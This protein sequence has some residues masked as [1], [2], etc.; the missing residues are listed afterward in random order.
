[1]IIPQAIEPY[2]DKAKLILNK[3][4]VRDI[5]FS[6][7]TYQILIDDPDVLEQ[8]WAFLQL[9]GTGLPK[10]YFCSC[11]VGSYP[12][13]CLH[14]AT[15]YLR[16]YNG[17]ERPLHQRFSISLWNQ[18]CRLSSE[19]G[20]L[21]PK[22]NNR[23]EGIDPEGN[24]FFSIQLKDPHLAPQL[25]EIIHH[26][27]EETEETSIKFSN[28]PQEE[29][30]KWR[31]GQ[32]SRALSY[33]LSY[34]ND[35]AKWLMLKQD[36]KEHFTLSFS[37]RNDGLPC[38]LTADF[39]TCTVNFSF[40]EKEL[41]LLI[42]TLKTVPSPIAVHDDPAEE[43]E[44]IT[45]DPQT[46]E[47]VVHAKSKIL[48]VRKGKATPQSISLHGWI[49]ITGEGFYAQDQH[50]L[51]ESP[52]FQG[53]RISRLLDEHF[54]L[55]QSLLD[56]TQLYEEQVEP[57]YTLAFDAK[58][59]LRIQAY[60]F[61]PGD[62]DL[63]LSKQFRDW[64]YIQDDGFYRLKDPY[65][66][67]LA[68][69]IPPDLLS[70][71]INQHRIWL[72]AQPGFET[73]LT[74]VETQVDYQLDRTNTLTFTRIG[75]IGKR[76]DFGQWVYFPKEGFFPKVRSHLPLPFEKGIPEDQVPG[77][78][79]LNRAE[80][81]LVPNFF[82]ETNPIQSLGL[83]IALNEKEQLVISPSIKFLPSYNKEEIRLIDGFVFIKG[84]GFYECPP[85]MRIPEHY[86]TEQVIEKKHLRQF[87]TVEMEELSPWLLSVDPKLKR[88]SEI[89]LY[90]DK[91]TPT[92]E[93]G[94]Y[95]ILMRY[96]TERGSLPIETISKKS[97]EGSEFLF[98][99]AGLLDLSEAR[100]RW[101]HA[102]HKKQV[103]HTDHGIVLST[104]ELLRLKV[105]E[106]LYLNPKDEKNYEEASA[107]LQEITEGLYFE[108][109]NLKGLKSTLRPYQ[110]AGVEWLWFLYQHGLS[111]LL[112]DDMG[113]GKTHQTM[114]LI[115][116]SVNAE[117]EKKRKSHFLII[118][119][120][121]VIYHWEEKLQLFL[122]HMRTCT[123]H[124]TARSL[125]DFHHEYDILLTSYGIWRNEQELLGQV[126]FE[127]AIF[128]EIQ[129]AKNRASRIHK[130]LTHVDAK[131]RVGL[132]GT[133]LENYL[134]ELKSL[135]DI[136]VPHYMPTQEEYKNFFVIPIEK[137]GNIER[138]L[139]LSRFI[140]PFILRRKKG[141]VL[142]DL[143]DKIEEISHCELSDQQYELYNS[144]LH[145]TRNQILREME[146]DKP[147][148]PYLHIFTILS[149]LKQICNHPA[150]YLKCPEDYKKYQSGKWDLFIEL[151]E[152]ARA[153]SQKIVI[154]SQYLAMIDI[155]ENHLHESGIKFASIRGS[156]RDRAH[157][158]RLF[159]HN[160]EYEVFVGSL[161]AVGLG[162]DLTAGS[163]VIHYDR[164]WNAAR[165]NQATD[166][167]HRI[168][169]KRGVQVFK[170]VTKG[171]FE[172]R[173]DQLILRKGR[174]MEEVIGSDNS[175]VIKRFDRNELLH[176]L[177][178]CTR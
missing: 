125:K 44:K 112:C 99:D 39:E 117:K 30:D 162:V 128:D 5:V 157:Q 12:D 8:Y 119:P 61:N 62:L 98:S 100:F 36:R 96:E 43:I 86:Q 48:Q 107:I 70:G 140:K 103:E 14:I 145:Q 131:M 164:W 15:A 64:V 176:L 134:E 92:G 149:S 139:L 10:D 177:D 97:R 60:L 136:V 120:T 147:S 111:A 115:A 163:V 173:I 104:M 74:S 23:Y 2:I 161:Q 26:H 109:P 18:I 73:H 50:H 152:E 126:P 77:F 90:I 124:G 37:F 66:E 49:Y 56:G 137:Q 141:E 82:H 101:I 34:W 93:R 57:H 7:G 154:F 146:R 31:K 29:L 123:Y 69:V 71:F 45:Y 27:P 108:K 19:K 159:N 47:L 95:S 171:T 174:M 155:I 13:P 132:T 79:R 91:I 113:L 143:P 110:I 135:F 118:C 83:S 51:L 67:S 94:L 22:T 106:T 16:I 21:I 68:K 41:T 165:E 65:F 38:S 33:L 85:D 142:R 121:S 158:L 6:G 25:K 81:E 63:P 148:I 72:N 166:R 78:I 151:L 169:Q 170:L 42:P 17:E 130:S 167:V 127:I 52:I 40:N 153:S 20:K 160:P 32:P 24:P 84:K 46:A 87:L 11:G 76:R 55:V 88:P 156:T 105:F 138:R 168:G 4:G 114:A 129:A 102:L 53:D 89:K 122:P 1:M 144:V 3:G 133:P 172:E 54:S 178:F 175:E 116:A 28:L 75:K 58:D 35:L 59:N 80:L 9:E 150:S